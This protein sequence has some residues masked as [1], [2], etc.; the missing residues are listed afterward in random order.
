MSNTPVD[1][2]AAVIAAA[3]QG[4]FH[5]KNLLKNNIA[6]EQGAS[7][8]YQI[9]KT[10]WVWSIWFNVLSTFTRVIR[11]ET[12]APMGLIGNFFSVNQIQ[13]AQE[14][15]ASC[16]RVL[17][18]SGM[19]SLIVGLTAYAI[20]QQSWWCFT[21]MG[22]VTVVLMVCSQ[23][24]MKMRRPQKETSVASPTPPEVQQAQPMQEM[25]EMRAE[26]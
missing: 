12:T 8:F 2:P 14:A 6:I 13:T 17:T 15:L 9:T 23:I 11:D 1:V 26:V 18:I 21:V 7:T 19:I 25:Q 16:A 3:K 4:D 22:V 24:P 10:S 20:T 5:S